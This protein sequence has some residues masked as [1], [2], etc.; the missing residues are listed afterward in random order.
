MNDSPPRPA[1]RRRRIVDWALRPCRWLIWS[2]R[3]LLMSSQD[4]GG[5]ARSR[6]RSTRARAPIGGAC[7]VACSTARAP[8]DLDLRL[9][10]LLREHHLEADPKTIEALGEVLAEAR[11]AS[12]ARLL[13]SPLL[14]LAE[15]GVCVAALIKESGGPREH[16]ILHAPPEPPTKTPTRV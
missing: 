2:L 8:L 11:E 6:A 5:F 12:E 15:R 10:D 9:R 13:N 1:E 7:S 4:R 16:L 14:A 3:R